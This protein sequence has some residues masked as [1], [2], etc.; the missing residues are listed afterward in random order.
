MRPEPIHHYE[1]AVEDEDDDV[2][3]TAAVYEADDDF[4]ANEE[5]KRSTAQDDNPGAT[6]K[7]K[8]GEGEQVPA[9][10]RLSN[11]V[12][13]MKDDINYRQFMKEE[14]KKLDGVEYNTK[15]EKEMEK[16]ILQRLQRDYH[17][18]DTNGDSADD[19]VALQS[20]HEFA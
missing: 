13:S 1:F 11:I 15:F 18:V 10:P 8:A 14:F 3:S 6:K 9:Q 17:L 20:K 4:G 12:L 7:S 19:D 5:K 16:E 2:S